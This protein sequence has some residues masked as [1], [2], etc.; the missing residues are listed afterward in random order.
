MESNE[1]PTDVHQCAPGLC[2]VFLLMKVSEIVLATCHCGDMPVGVI[3][4][5]NTVVT[6]R[7]LHQGAMNAQPSGEGL[8]GL[9]HG[10]AL[11]RGQLQNVGLAAGLS[12]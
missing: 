6:D 9:Q 5:G 4:K 3:S 2:A 11:L 10:A 1:A 12:V 8:V 7:A